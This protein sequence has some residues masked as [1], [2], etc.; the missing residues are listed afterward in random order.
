M[1]ENFAVFIQVTHQFRKTLP[2]GL[3]T[4]VFKFP[5]LLEHLSGF[6]DGEYAKLCFL[7]EI[8][9]GPLF[10]ILYFIRKNFLQMFCKPPPE[11]FF[12]ENTGIQNFFRL[13]TNYTK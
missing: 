2:P 7:Y 8:P 9:N 10:K 5:L 12:L 3:S 6:G 13:P 4:E 1:L 11:L